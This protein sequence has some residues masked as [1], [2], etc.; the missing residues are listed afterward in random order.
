MIFLSL[1]DIYDGHKINHPDPMISKLKDVEG[2]NKTKTIS[3]DFP[4]VTPFM[5]LIPLE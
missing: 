5:K 1:Y 2:Q 3:D 4:L